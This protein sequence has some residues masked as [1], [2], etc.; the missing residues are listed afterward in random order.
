MLD[1]LAIHEAT[2][3]AML[4]ALELHARGGKPPEALIARAP[5]PTRQSSR[6]GG[7]IITVLP[8]QGF[9][10]YRSRGL[11]ALLFG[12]TSTA[13]LTAEVR[14]AAAD[15]TVSALLILTDSPGGEVGGVEELAAAIS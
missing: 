12:G 1:V 8:L 10:A 13:T 2:Y 6:S 5:A 9:M 11:F 4:A 15:P 14:R 3:R 7:G